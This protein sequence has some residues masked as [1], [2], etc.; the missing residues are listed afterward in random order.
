MPRAK[1]R[2]D[3]LPPGLDHL[4]ESVDRSVNDAKARASLALERMNA[5]AEALL[6]RRMDRWV[7]VATGLGTVMDKTRAGF[8][9]TPFRLTDTEVTALMSG[10]DLAAKIV[11]KRPNEMFRR[12]YEIESQKPGD[13]DKGPAG[14]LHAYANEVLEADTRLREGVTYGREYGGA[15]VFMGIND[16]RFPWE[17]VDEENIES[18][19][20]LNVID[21][22]YSY[23]QS[24]YSDYQ[25]PKYGQAQ[26]YL[27]SNAVATSAYRSE[28]LTRF[29]Y[30]RTAAPVDTMQTNLSK[31][32]RSNAQQQR[33]AGGYSVMNIHESR[34][35]RFDGV[36]A[37]VI[38]RQTL[39]GWSWSVLQRVYEPLRQTDQS[40]DSLCYLISDAS[41]GV[42]KLKGLLQALTS[43][44]EDKL[45]AR[46]EQLERSRSVARLVAIDGGGQEE[47]TRVST[48]LSGIPE[49]IDRMMQRLAAAADMPVEE[50]FGLAPGGLASTGAGQS[51][52]I[53]W[54]DTIASEQQNVLAPKIKRL[55]RLLGLAKSGPLK[56]KDVAWKVNFHPLYAP[57]DDEIA[58][59]RLKNAQRDQIYV[60]TEV[61]TPQQVALTLT[62]VYSSIDAEAIE[63]EVD[64]KTQFDPF[65]KDPLASKEAQAQAPIDQAKAKGAAHGKAVA[66]ILSKRLNQAVV[67]G[68]EQGSLSEGQSPTVPLPGSSLH[69][70]AVAPAGEGE[71]TP[72]DPKS[73]N[74]ADDERR[75]KGD[76]LLR[77]D[78]SNLA[79]A[80]H[81][82]LAT[83]YP[84]E[85]I[86]WVKAA[87]WKGPG[88]VPLDRINF[89][90]RAQW[91]ASHDPAKVAVHKGRIN[92]GIEKPIIL[93]R[94]PHSKKM[95]II[96]GHHRGLGYRELRRNP[97][98]YVATVQAVNGPWD[99][100]H[101][102]QREGG[103]LE[104]TQLQRADEWDESL[105]PRES[106]GEFGEGGG[107]SSGASKAAA[108]AAESG[109]NAGKQSDPR[110]KALRAV[111]R[112]LAATPKILGKVVLDEVKEKIKDAK[113]AF[114]GVEHF[115][116]G[117]P[118]S[119]EEKKAI[120]HLVVTVAAS[121]VA[122]HLTPLLHI[123]GLAGEHAGEWA[124]KVADQVI[125]HVVEKFANRSL[126]LDA[127]GAAAAATDPHKWLADGIVR[128][129]ADSIDQ[130]HDE[131][132]VRDD[133]T[134]PARKDFNEEDHPRDETGKFSAGGGG[135][136]AP[137]GSGPTSA[138]AIF[139]PDEVAGLPREVRQP[140]SN[141]DDLEKQ[142]PKAQEEQL[143][144]L[145]RG[146]GVA[147]DIGARVVRK[148]LGEPVDLSKPG[149]V[150]VIAPPKGV[151]R[152]EEKVKADYGGDWSKVG[153]L[154]RASVAVDSVKDVRAVI[155]RLKARG[156]VI[157]RTPKDRMSQPT[158]TGYRDLLLNVR[159]PSG[160]VGELQI[161]LKPMLQAKGGEGHKL[162]E[163][164]RTIEAQSKGRAMTP[165]EQGLVSAAT[166][167]SKALYDAAWARARADAGDWDEWK[168][169]RDEDGKFGSGG[170]GETTAAPSPRKADAGEFRAAF[171]EAFAGSDFSNHVTHYSEADL[172]GM[173]ALYLTPDGKAGVAVHDHGDG[174]VEATALFNNGSSQKGAGIA[175]LKHAVQDA[176]VNYV[177]CY[178]PKLN[179]L[180]E[181]AGFKVTS[182][183]PFNAEYA[184]PTWNYDKFDH[185]SYY[186]MSLGGGDRRRSGE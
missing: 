101:A 94:T 54:Y 31:R 85:A 58:G 135:G 121:V 1:K 26:S 168:H 14:E 59:T 24:W 39:A 68:G 47:F 98:A 4:Q 127:A 145:D 87:H 143:D 124:E 106:N 55:Y 177:E 89:A 137:K 122:G 79:D 141:R 35:L 142:I 108:P 175:L 138:S 112:A 97:K 61:V 18:V 180:Y 44:N 82:Q 109:A 8:F 103:L 70:G 74:A 53:K 99:S 154:V 153:D 90:N 179:K 144:L 11:E 65:E 170:T 7:N 147:A 128:A 96:D 76:A 2:A 155:D 12:G 181:G 123:S 16:G 84:P 164:I 134:K 113:E 158:A 93:V 186:T 30:R 120:A 146:K 172:K 50:L 185:P 37:D 27:V 92:A 42:M 107:S 78:A 10:S 163:A 167:K 139:R 104:S 148:D 62:E 48:P 110:F 150:V 129:I 183:S 130:V 64:A 72:S 169:P 126:K 102:S 67:G 33:S 56:G 43:G 111:G 36:Q 46:L 88:R 178:G 133:G 6:E 77:L 38:T 95:D 60:T 71:G 117:E 86:A 156:A 25:R 119:H 66:D 159:Y 174:R 91:A 105:H 22:R 171:E 173:K 45:A 80:I 115:L 100:M 184:A 152:A 151:A 160:H 52:R 162:Y 114:H 5:Q 75:A 40:F 34:L 9:E 131:M 3:A 140:T 32:T 136:E 29:G 57:T 15:V 69:G 166:T 23:V 51:S 149:P 49:S 182:E 21:R 41:Q 13:V 116:K 20:Y 161:H 157:A 28:D 19:D 17:P 176:G 73:G 125:H 165:Q 83:D 63:E 81:A 118:V 132:D